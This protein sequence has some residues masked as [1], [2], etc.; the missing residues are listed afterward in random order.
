[1]ME[2]KMESTVLLQAHRVVWGYTR[3]L[4]KNLESFI[5]Y[6]DSKTLNL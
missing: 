3:I 5:F 4:E 2:K 1:M 6:R